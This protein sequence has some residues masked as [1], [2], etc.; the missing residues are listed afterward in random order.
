ME[1][2]E[3]RLLN[4]LF[5][6]VKVW[7]GIKT[8]YKLGWCEL[9]DTATI[10]CPSCSASSCNCRDCEECRDDFNHFNTLKT[11]V[12]DYVTKEE[13]ETIQKGRRLEKLILKSLSR[14]ESEIDWAKMKESGNL[15]QMDE[16]YFK[17]FLDKLKV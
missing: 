3:E 11:T 12:F 13:W 17:E 4:D 16:K 5:G 7:K 2:P 9:C 15:C 8:N 6:N 10:S 1:T 14:N